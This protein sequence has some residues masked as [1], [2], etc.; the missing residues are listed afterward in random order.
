VTGTWSAITT[1]TD[2]VGDE[3][4]EYSVSLDPVS[5]LAAADQV[6]VTVEYKIGD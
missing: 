1:S 3:P 2:A 4:I 5:S 6:S